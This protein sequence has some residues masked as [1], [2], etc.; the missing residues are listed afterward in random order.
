MPLFQM[1][2]KPDIRDLVTVA[3]F[4]GNTMMRYFYVLEGNLY[5][6]I[7]GCMTSHPEDPTGHKDCCPVSGWLRSFDALWNGVK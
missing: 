5:R 1:K 2:T 4:A 7:C 3:G 6:C